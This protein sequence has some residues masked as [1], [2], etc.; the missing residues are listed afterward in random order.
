MR[1]TLLA[2]PHSDASNPS[3][4]SII[5]AQTRHKVLQYFNADPDHFDVVFTA[6]ATAAIK[7]VM[8][9][10]S[11]HEDGFDYYFHRNCH[12]SLV[13]VREVAQQSCCFESDEQTET[14][15]ATGQGSFEKS[16]LRPT[17]FA[18][19]AQSNMD[20]QRLPLS[21]PKSIRDSGHHPN[22]YTLL[23]VAA[24]VATGY[25]DL[26]DP[27]AAPDFLAM[28]F[29]KIFG[30]PD[31][32]A[33]IVRKDSAH[34]LNRRR[35]FGGG[36]TEMTTVLGA[37]PWVAR[38][39]E[40]PHAR[41]E[42]G[43]IAIRSILALSCAIDTHQ[44]L[45]DGIVN[46]SKH[47][48]WLASSLYDRL[49]TLQHANGVPVC[50][51]YRAFDSRHGDSVTQGATIALNIKARD[52]L[53]ISAYKVGSMLRSQN[54]HVRTGSVCNPGGI[55]CAL[56]LDSALIK[57]AYLAGFR[58]NNQDDL[59]EGGVI[60]G[61]VR[62]TFGAMS[63]MKDVDTIF[64][65]IKELFMDTSVELQSPTHYRV[66]SPISDEKISSNDSSCAAPSY[67]HTTQ[68]T[69]SQGHTRA[70]SIRKMIFGCFS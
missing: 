66:D 42:D 1:S 2:N 39:E 54:I 13:G 19:P 40:S 20:G 15:I 26:S 50:H 70:W 14:W 16:G 69:S 64:T 4:S 12:T 53:W 28:S 51:I 31:L 60:F 37:D 23:D 57:R 29:Y 58:C 41:L 33:L 7:L 61:V 44:Q 10:L 3:A 45:F 62:I 43:T 34:I 25:L 38:K 46:V 18:Y 9:C 27:T 63:T 24:L 32:G 30:F 59:R 35:Y 68:A 56:N 47:T 65:C 36:T 48:G 49:S 6:N 17:L 52:G 8:D 22:T 21:W 5:V 55:A 67:V 11:G